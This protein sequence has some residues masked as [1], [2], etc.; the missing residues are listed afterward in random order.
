[1]ITTL[2]EITVTIEYRED[3]KWS[4]NNFQTPFTLD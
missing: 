2:V 4:V 1:M 3:G